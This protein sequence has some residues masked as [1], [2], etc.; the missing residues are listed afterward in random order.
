MP[1]DLVAEFLT[2]W[3]AMIARQDLDVLAPLIADELTFSSPALFRPKRG[4]TEASPLLRDV[5]AT[6]RDYRVMRTWVDGREVLLEF[7]ASA[8]GRALQGIDRISLDERGRMTHL[9]V[10]VRPYRGLVAVMTAVARRQID[11]LGF[12]ARFVARARMRLRVGR[13]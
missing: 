9:T 1:P 13:G 3:H 7:E 12:P 8:G 4:K 5:L 10:Y 11:R 2:R 6:L